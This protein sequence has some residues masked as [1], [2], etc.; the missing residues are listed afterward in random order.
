M[1]DVRGSKTMALAEFRIT[2]GNVKEAVS[3]LREAT[4]WVVNLNIPAWNLEDLTEGRLLQDLT[5]ENSIY[6]FLHL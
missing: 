1:E 6:Y 2:H 3:V 5:P 4:E